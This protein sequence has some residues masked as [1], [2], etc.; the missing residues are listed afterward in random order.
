MLAAGCNRAQGRTSLDPWWRQRGT[1]YKELLFVS[2]RLFFL[3]LCLP[4]G[5]TADAGRH[6]GQTRSDPL[7]GG[8]KAGRMGSAEWDKE[9]TRAKELQELAVLSRV[10]CSFRHDLMHDFDLMHGLSPSVPR[11]ASVSRASLHMGEETRIPRGLTRRALSDKSLSE[12]MLSRRCCEAAENVSKDSS[13]PNMRRAHWMQMPDLGRIN[14][15]RIRSFEHLLNLSHH[16]R[17]P[18]AFLP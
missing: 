11:G 2:S 1:H 10:N 12:I 15:S 9:V 13:E 6:V 8:M 3:L 4:T 18:L 17:L 16:F 14:I 7:L 5:K